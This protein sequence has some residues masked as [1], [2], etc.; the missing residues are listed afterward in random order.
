MI[1][2]RFLFQLAEYERITIEWHD[3]THIDALYT[4]TPEMPAPIIAI[5]NS[6]HTHERKL[7]CVLAHELGHHFLTA[8][9]HAIAASTTNRI[10]ASKN[11]HLATK[12]AV[13]LL[14]PTDVFLEC[15]NDG[16]DFYELV[17]YFYVLPDWI[18]FKSDLIKLDEQHTGTIGGS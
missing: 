11:E 7:R 17:D 2:T 8:G 9:H 16:M 10:Y 1:P 14:V 3:F 18:R 4:Y 6:L 12:W 13:N 5:S 15:I